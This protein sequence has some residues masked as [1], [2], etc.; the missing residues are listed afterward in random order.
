MSVHFWWYLIG[1]GLYILG[2]YHGIMYE[3]WRAL[4]DISKKVNDL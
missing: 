1:L 2:N 4:Q 3:K